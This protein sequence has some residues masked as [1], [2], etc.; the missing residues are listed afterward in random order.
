MNR[1]GQDIA[2]DRLKHALGPED[3]QGP[4]QGLVD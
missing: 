2:D 3:K 1:S 4:Q